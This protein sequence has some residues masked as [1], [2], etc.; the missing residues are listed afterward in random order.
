MREN[1]RARPLRDYLGMVYSPSAQ[2]VMCVWRVDGIRR[3]DVRTYAFT[4]DVWMAPTPDGKGLAAD[5]VRYVE[6]PV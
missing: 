3:Q 6:R 4:I 2:D 1:H 5:P